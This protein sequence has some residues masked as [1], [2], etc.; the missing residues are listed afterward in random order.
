[1]LLKAEVGLFLRWPDT[2]TAACR[3]AHIFYMYVKHISQTK[4]LS[5]RVSLGL[6]LILASFTPLQMKSISMEAS[7]VT[8]VLNVCEIMS[9]PWS[10]VKAAAGNSSASFHSLG[11]GVFLLEFT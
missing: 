5:Q 9:E 1:M 2:F 6:C 11:F 10:I 4:T 8:L 3:Y 7:K